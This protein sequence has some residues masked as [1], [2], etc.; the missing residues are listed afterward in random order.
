MKYQTFVKI[1]Y[2]H[3]IIKANFIR[4]IFYKIVLPLFYFINKI[5]YPKV[6]NLDDIEKKKQKFFEKDLA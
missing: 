6:K 1:Y 4:K 2:S 5:L 3:R